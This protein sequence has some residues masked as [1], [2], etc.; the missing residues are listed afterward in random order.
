[1]RDPQRLLR[2]LLWLNSPFSY[3][4]ALL[5]VLMMLSVV[6]D[7]IARLVF[8]APTLWVI[9]VNEYML[10]YLTFIPAAWILLRG[11]HV[12]V[13]LVVERLSPRAR[14]IF[15]LVGDLMGLAY[16]VILTWQSWLVT[17]DA[18]RGGYRFSTAI[19]FLQYPVFAIIP[20]GGAWLG[21][22]FLVRFWVGVRGGT[23]ASTAGH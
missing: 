19:A 10:V 15:E 4:T 13:E 20:L 21:L 23:P 5:T 14:R 12:K 6:Y 3:V 9:D 18:Y 16:C 8:S 7:V 22:A 11:G 2:V 17:V 1:M